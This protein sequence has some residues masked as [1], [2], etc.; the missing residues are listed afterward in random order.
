VSASSATLDQALETAMRFFAESVVMFDSLRFRAWAEM[1]LTTTQLRVLFL[2]RAN[3][4]VTS[5]ELAQTIG[6]TPPTIS[7][8]VDRLVRMGLVRREDDES[9]RRL[10][11]NLL[12]EHGGST[13]NVLQ[14]RA[15]TFTRRL[16]SELQPAELDALI[17]GLGAVVRAG[18]T[19]TPA[20]LAP[21]NPTPPRC[22]EP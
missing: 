8:V 6:V 22:E 3:P 19:V 15:Q 5:G 10:V 1:G 11:R 7:G 17:V 18:E 13:C 9:D 20:D 21:T 14:Q 12:T 4:G 16:L 2:V